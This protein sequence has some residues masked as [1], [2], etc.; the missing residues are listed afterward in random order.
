[1]LYEPGVEFY[2]SLRRALFLN[3]MNGE[4]SHASAL[5][6]GVHLAEAEKQS[7]G[8]A[9]RL[10]SVEEFTV[11]LACTPEVRE[12][13]HAEFRRNMLDCAA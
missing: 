7:P 2:V 4:A 13:M 3:P 5:A 9:K 8:S 12:A 6:A 10:L 11:P 1:M